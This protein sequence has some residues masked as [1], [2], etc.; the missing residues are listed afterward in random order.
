[1]APKQKKAPAK[2]TKGGDAAGSRSDCGLTRA[3][4]EEVWPGPRPPSSSSS[5][6]PS[7]DG[8]LC[9][10]ESW[11]VCVSMVTSNGPAEEELS[12]CLLSAVQQPIRAHFT[13]LTWDGVLQKVDA[14]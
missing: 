2:K 7:S 11:R 1:M 9:P 10:Q 4:F 8:L 14:V 13:L 12:R 6:S 5:L 3:A